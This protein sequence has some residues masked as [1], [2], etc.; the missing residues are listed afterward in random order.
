MKLQP[1]NQCHEPI[2]E[3]TD[4]LLSKKHYKLVEAT[5]SKW[6]QWILPMSILEMWRPG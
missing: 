6:I 1:G 2:I 5:L 4:I 3:D